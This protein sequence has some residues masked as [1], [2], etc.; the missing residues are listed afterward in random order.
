[1][2]PDPKMFFFIAAS[3]ADAAAVRPSTS[4]GLITDFSKSNPDLKIHP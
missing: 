3:V 1:M 2:T 4:N